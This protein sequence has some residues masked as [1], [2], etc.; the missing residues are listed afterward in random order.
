MEMLVIFFLYRVCSSMG[1]YLFVNI[2]NEIYRVI[3]IEV[4]FKREEIIGIRGYE[5]EEERRMGK[6]RV[7]V[8][9]DLVCKSLLL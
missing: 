3:S 8:N 6:G 1:F 2:V 9:I 5:V 4:Y 7:S